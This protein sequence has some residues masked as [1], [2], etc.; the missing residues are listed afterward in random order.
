MSELNKAKTIGKKVA[1][2]R[3]RNLWTQREL[4]LRTGIT[5]DQISRIERG[6]SIPT[7]ST[8]ERF[9]EAFDLPK[10]TLPDNS[11]TSYSEKGNYSDNEAA[12]LYI[13]NGLREKICVRIS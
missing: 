5:R 9:E 1:A 8:I 13:A 10:W 4:S 2:L 11:E 7:L 3:K 12:L 6:K